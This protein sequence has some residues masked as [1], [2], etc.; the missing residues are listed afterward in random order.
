MVVPWMS[1]RTTEEAGIGLWEYTEYE[2]GEKEL[3][4]LSGGQC[5]NWQRRSFAAA[6]VKRLTLRT[7]NAECGVRILFIA[8]R[9]WRLRL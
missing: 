2:T 5:W 7:R 9:R 1:V 8:P 3:Y 6:A 4:D